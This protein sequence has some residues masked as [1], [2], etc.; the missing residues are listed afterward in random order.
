MIKKEFP[1]ITSPCVKKQ[2]TEL[3]LIK[4]KRNKGYE[5]LPGFSLKKIN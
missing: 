1:K 2:F 3:Y 4:S 5:K